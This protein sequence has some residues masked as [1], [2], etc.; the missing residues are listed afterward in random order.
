MPVTRRL[1]ERG[2]QVLRSLLVCR[3]AGFV[4]KQP[5]KQVAFR[6]ALVS[7][8]L[9][10]PADTVEPTDHR[11]EVRS[12]VA[13]RGPCSPYILLTAIHLPARYCK[14]YSVFGQS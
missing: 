13:V 1:L 6:S 3:G 12:L 5:T 9:E 11:R 2:G 4:R 14:R 7:P 10:A 8:R